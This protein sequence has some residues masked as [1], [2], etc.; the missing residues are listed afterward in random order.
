M[1]TLVVYHSRT[2]N[3]KTVA[4]ALVQKLSADQEEIKSTEMK[5]GLFGYLKAGHQAMKKLM[6][7]IDEMKIDPSGYDLV[8]IGTPVWAWTMASPVRT[9]IEQ[10]KQKFPKVAFFCTCGDKQSNTFRDMQDA[11]GKEPMATLEVKAE[12]IKSGKE[13][14]LVEEF[15]MKLER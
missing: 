13:K 15:L 6:P 5:R 7:E 3:T 12:L 9:F 10:Y 11:C 8:I 2:G 1:K 14:G 4:Q